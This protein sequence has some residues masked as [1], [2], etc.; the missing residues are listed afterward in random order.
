[1]LRLI[2]S[3]VL[4][5]NLVALADEKIATPVAPLAANGGIPGLMPQTKNKT[6]TLIKLNHMNPKR[7]AQLVEPMLQRSKIEDK[8][9]YEAG[10]KGCSA[11][12]PNWWFVFNLHLDDNWKTGVD[13]LVSIEAQNSLLV[14]GSKD[15]V[16][17]LQQ[18][19]QLWDV[20]EIETDMVLYKMN[21]AML[22]ELNPLS[23]A[24]PVVFPRFVTMN[25]DR[26]I[27]NAAIAGGQAKTTV[28]HRMRGLSGEPSCYGFASA[29]AGE[30]YMFNLSY[31]FVGNE[32]GTISTMINPSPPYFQPLENNPLHVKEVGNS[33]PAFISRPGDTLAIAL[34][35][36][37]QKQ[38]GWLCL[39]TSRLVKEDTVP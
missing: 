35:N 30:S 4:L 2:L 16:E 3:L 12:N 6:T 34:P 10:F 1:M 9:T 29:E 26:K 32:D 15:A 36:N 27:I 31:M 20:P 21:A 25:P 28:V 24:S 38:Q 22:K 11:L 14:R 23:S 39:L 18:L 37:K 7:M 8:S 5:W 13:S 19:V 17:K 33:Q